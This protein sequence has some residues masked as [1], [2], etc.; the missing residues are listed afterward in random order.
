MKTW[1]V[2]LCLIA[3]AACASPF[4]AR[5]PSPGQP[6]NYSAPAFDA[7]LM[8]AM[9]AIAYAVEATG[10]PMSRDTEDETVT[11][12]GVA[13]GAYALSAAYGVAAGGKC[14]RIERAGH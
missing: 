4:A 7:S 11:G 13:A 10:T 14:E 12:L 2:G 8:L 6:C 3:M 1:I 9:F 5:R